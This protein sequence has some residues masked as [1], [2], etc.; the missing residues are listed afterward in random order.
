MFFIQKQLSADMEFCEHVSTL[1]K[2]D[3]YFNCQMCPSYEGNKIA[4]SIS[5]QSHLFKSKEQRK[6]AFADLEGVCVLL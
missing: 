1:V 3:E 5:Y 6:G 4:S 2:L